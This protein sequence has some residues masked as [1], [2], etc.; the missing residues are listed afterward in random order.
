[1]LVIAGVG[2]WF[3][4][5]EYYRELASFVGLEL[6][7]GGT[8]VAVVTPDPV[9]PTPPPVQPDPSTPPVGGTDTPDVTEAPDPE[10]ALVARREFR[11]RVLSAIELGFTGEV[12]R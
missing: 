2:G 3:F 12:T 7:A 5:P 10:V 11:S 9:T 4:F 6:P 8:S 1:M